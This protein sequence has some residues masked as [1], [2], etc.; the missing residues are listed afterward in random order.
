MDFYHLQQ[1]N[2][3]EGKRW[4]LHFQQQNPQGRRTRDF[5][6]WSYS[7]EICKPISFPF[8]SWEKFICHGSDGIWPFFCKRYSGYF[9]NLASRQ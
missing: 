3:E 5:S 4:C 7:C 9:Y 8:G 6:R 2:T 1:Q